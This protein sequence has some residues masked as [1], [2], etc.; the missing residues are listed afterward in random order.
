MCMTAIFGS[1]LLLL[2]FEDDFVEW[3]YYVNTS[4]VIPYIWL[5]AVFTSFV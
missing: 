4:C 1:D 5:L 2:D 3:L